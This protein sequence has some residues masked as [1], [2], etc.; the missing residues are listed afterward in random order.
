MKNPQYTKD[1]V[2][3][4]LLAE[5]LSDPDLPKDYTVDDF[6]DDAGIDKE[7]RSD[8]VFTCIYNQTLEILKTK[9]QGE[10]K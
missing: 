8:F 5:K 2:Y 4:N 1:F 6:F 9:E 3:A 10:V 7:H